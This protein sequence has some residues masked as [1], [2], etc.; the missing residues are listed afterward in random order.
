MLIWAT[1]AIQVRLISVNF[2]NILFWSNFIALVFAF[3]FAFRERKKYIKIFF[4]YKFVL[5][6]VGICALINGLTYFYSIKNTSIA[7]ALMTHYMTPVMV[8]V[9][10]PFF[11]KERFTF[12]IFTA[13]VLS[14][15]GLIIIIDPQKLQFKSNDFYGIIAGLISAVAYA[16]VI[17]IGRYIKTNINPLN[18]IIAQSGIAVFVMSFFCDWNIFSFDQQS[19]FYLTTFG[20]F[21]IFFAAILFFKSLTKVDASIVGIIGYIEPVGAIMLGILFL[22]E[23]MNLRIAIG[24][25]LILFSSTLVNF[26]FK[27][28]E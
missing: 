1:T 10:A 2:Y 13:L 24:A 6:S 19:L 3:I 20:I 26:K 16:V 14:I 23:P 17:I 18:Y 15:L 5:L 11:L 9:A 4:E 12:I 21:N 7:N 28:C 22:K 27:K 8:A 25:F